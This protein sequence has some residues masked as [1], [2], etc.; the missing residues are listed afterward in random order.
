M[1]ASRVNICFHGVGTPGRVLESGESRY[2]ITADT[3]HRV[4]DT[5]MDRNDVSLSFDDGNL[6]DIELGLP[7]LLDR[8][9]HATFFVL[10]GRLGVPGSLDVDSVRELSRNGMRVGTHG[11]D[12]VAWRGLDAAAARRELVEARE[13]IQGAVGVVV[14]QAA[15]PLGRYDRQLLVR[16]RRLGYRRVHTSDRRWAREGR[17]LQPR[18]SV[19]DQDTAATL[20]TDVLERAPVVRRVKLSTVGLVKSLR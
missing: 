20:R 4:L 10:A 1:S 8:G 17:W 3:F 14:D 18:F 13:G 5:V 6:S 15:L 9:L 19:R 2:W 12:H 7:A 11:M 16:L